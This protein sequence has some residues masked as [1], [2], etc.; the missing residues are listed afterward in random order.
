MLRFLSRGALAALLLCATAATAAAGD[1]TFQ[2]AEG[3][4]NK[5]TFTSNAPFEDIVGINNATGGELTLD[6]E[7]PARSAKGKVTLK[8]DQFKTGIDLRDEHFRSDQWLD[9][10]A[11]PTA[12]FEIT[13]VEGEGKLAFGAKLKG[14]VHGKLTIKGV[15]KPVVA[16]V[17]VSYH[18]HTPQMK[19]VW[20]NNH[21][22]VVK[23]SFK[24]NVKDFGVK[25]APQLFGQKVA[26]E[27]DVQ[28]KL[29]GVQQ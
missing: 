16:D 13:K 11:H 14:K 24:I 25:G 26:E 28:L 17:T 12:T 20:I 19:K 5:V 9:T 4:L 1:T 21:L 7:A 29:A 27:V 6:L 2:F 22:L 18:K 15:T 10:K 23:G 3:G 8:M